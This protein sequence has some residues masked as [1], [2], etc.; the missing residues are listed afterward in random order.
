MVSLPAGRN[1]QPDNVIPFEQTESES[2]YFSPLMKSEL[3]EKAAK[4]IPDPQILINVISKRVRHL[5]GGRSPVV[6]VRPGMGAAD[7]AL[8]ELIEGKIKIAEPEKPAKK[9]KKK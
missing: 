8:T 9:K 5:N 6:D 1:V 4:I 7:I 2:G 3:V